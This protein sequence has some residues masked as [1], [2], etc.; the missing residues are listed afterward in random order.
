MGDA[1]CSST[2]SGQCTLR[3][4]VQEGQAVNRAVVVPAGLYALTLGQLVVTQNLTLTG[5]GSG[6]TKLD[7][8]LMSRIFDIGATGFAYIGDVTI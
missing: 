8:K 6:K 1:I 7:G 5:A 2:P 4:A 3:A